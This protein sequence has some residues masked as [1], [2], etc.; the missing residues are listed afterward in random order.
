MNASKAKKEASAPKIHFRMSGCFHCFHSF[1]ENQL[2]HVNIL[3]VNT[4][5]KTG[6]LECPDLGF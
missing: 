1:N 2:L 6:V 5:Y 4:F 3:A